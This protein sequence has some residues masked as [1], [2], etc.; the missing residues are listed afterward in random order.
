[1]ETPVA[2]EPVHQIGPDSSPDFIRR[3][4][5][6]HLD[7]GSAE[8]LSAGQPGQSGAHDEDW[9]RDVAWHATRFP[10]VRYLCRAASA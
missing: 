8:A 4:Q 3:L 6:L 5:H 2:A 9:G 10:F 1:L 7:A